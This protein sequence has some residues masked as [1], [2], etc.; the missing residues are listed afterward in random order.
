MRRTDIP[1][2]RPIPVEAESHTM[3]KIDA[4]ASCIFPSL[5]PQAYAFTGIGFAFENKRTL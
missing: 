5:R 1:A 2:G 3:G 4:E